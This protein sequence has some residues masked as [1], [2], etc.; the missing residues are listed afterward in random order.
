MSETAGTLQK[1]C[2]QCGGMTDTDARFCKHCAFDLSKSSLDYDA[3]VVTPKSK[4]KTN[5]N[6][7]FWIVGAAFIGL[8]ILGLIGAYL[9]K[10]NSTQSNVATTSPA[11]TPTP[12]MSDKAKQVE[13]KILRGET[14]TNSDLLGLSAYELR[15][16][17]NVHFARYGRKY[18]GPGLRDYFNTRAWYKPSD[19]YNESM[20]TSNDKV[21]INMILAAEN[22]AK[23]SESVANSNANGNHSSQ[24]TAVVANTNDQSEATS[25]ASSSSGGGLTNSNVQGA[26]RSFMSEFTKGGNINVEGVQE[27]PNQNAATADLR[28][29]NWVCSTTYE[30][31][32][33]KQT[34]P[35]VTRDKFGMPSSTFG[36]RLRTYNMSGLAVLKRYNDGRWVLKEVRVGSGLNTITIRGTQEVR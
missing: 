23:Q 8:L 5:P 3:T 2:P 24:D 19:S 4:W 15:V 30:G 12:A 35:P 27:L 31:G 21:N 20:I 25:S 28:F 10:R 9:Y 6:S 13:D 16:L 22:Q 33:S 18:D 36:L 11:S 7:I 17:R 1:L 26:V 14:L 29:S 32:L 34:P